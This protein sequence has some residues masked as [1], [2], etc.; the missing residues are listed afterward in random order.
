MDEPH[1]I[2]WY[3]GHAIRIYRDENESPWRVVF[4]PRPCVDELGVSGKIEFPEARERTADAAKHTAW[5]LAQ[6]AYLKEL[7]PI[8]EILW[9]PLRED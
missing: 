5:A 3:H 7:L 4:E 8:Q 1:F 9:R 2:G 6:N